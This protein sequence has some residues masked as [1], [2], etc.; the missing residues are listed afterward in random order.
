M[1]YSEK[2]RMNQMRAWPDQQ[3]HRY[4]DPSKKNLSFWGRLLLECNASWHEMNSCPRKNNTRSE[5]AQA[6]TA[7]NSQQIHRI[8]RFGALPQKKHEEPGGSPEAIMKTKKPRTKAQEGWL[9]TEAAV[10]PAV[11][12]KFCFF[13]QKIIVLQISFNWEP[14]TYFL[15]FS[16]RVHL[17]SRCFDSSIC[18]P[19]GKYHLFRIE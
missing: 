1:T 4:H 19:F 13:V 6:V 3:Q 7:L 2:S 16:V 17:A 10:A 14:V 15:I 18:S 12:P 11:D 9:D 5:I 8:L